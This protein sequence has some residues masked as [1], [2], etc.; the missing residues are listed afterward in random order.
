MGKPVVSTALPE[1]VAIRDSHPSLLKIGNTVEAFEACLSE[2]LQGDGI[3][4]IQERIEFG[5]RNGWENRLEKMDELVE[6]KL[7]E[8]QE[9][10]ALQ[11][12]ASLKQIY[13]RSKKRVTAVLLVLGLTWL[14]ISYTP[15][16]WWLASP[17]KLSDPP[18]KA[19]AIVVLGGGVG[20]TGTPGKNTIER[21]RYAADLY[22][23]D[24]A[25]VIIFS[26]GYVYSYQEAED[27]KLIATSIGVP[28]EAIL[29]ETRSSN[30]YENVRFVKEILDQKNWHSILLVSA[31]YHLR[32]VSLVFRKLAP[33][34]G[35]RYLPVQRSSFYAKKKPVQLSQIRAL[36]HE[37]FG[38]LYSWWKGYV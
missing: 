14:T 25:P 18:Q 24:W 23:A 13:R 6:A 26:S 34:I 33:G 15:L 29:L 2:S 20:E 30:T 8:K 32:R 11:W 3:G 28:K 36:F 4:E 7:R 1:V 31:P 17:L 35:V 10:E 19:D 38:I 12:T 22:N 16:F 9:L 37:V 21:A 27:M 5:R